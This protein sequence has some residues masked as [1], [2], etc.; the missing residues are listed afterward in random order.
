MEGESPTIFQV[1][2]VRYATLMVAI[3]WVCAVL[4][5]LCQWEGA[6]GFLGHFW[7]GASAATGALLLGVVAP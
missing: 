2:F 6:G 3:S 4:A 1:C 7:P 5:L